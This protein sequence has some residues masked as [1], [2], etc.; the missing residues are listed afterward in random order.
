[1]PQDI[2]KL[3]DDVANSL[4]SGASIDCITTALRLILQNSIDANASEITVSL[5]LRNRALT[6]SDNGL[7]MTRQDLSCFGRQNHTSKHNGSEVGYPK[8]YGFKGCS[9]FD[10]SNVAK[11]T[12]ISRH[13]KALSGW[14]KKLGGSVGYI[15]CP[16]TETEKPEKGTIVTVKDFFHNLP[17]RSKNLERSKTGKILDQVRFDVFEVLVSHPEVKICVN[18]GDGFEGETKLLETRGVESSL[19]DANRLLLCLQDVFGL[20][21]ESS[22][23]KPVHA[24]FTDCVIDG[25]ISEEPRYHRKIHLLFV[26]GLRCEDPALLRPISRAFGNVR[27]HWN[28]VG[29][30][31]GYE[32]YV[33]K[34]S[35]P[36][37]NHKGAGGRH[38]I[39]LETQQRQIIHALVFKLIESIFKVRLN[40][41]DTNVSKTLKRSTSSKM[42]KRLNDS[43][44]L[45]SEFEGGRSFVLKKPKA[46]SS[47]HRDCF[48]P[49]S[50]SIN[51]DTAVQTGGHKEGIVEAIQESNMSSFLTHREHTVDRSLFSRIHVVNQVDKK[52]LLLKSFDSNPDL[53]SLILLD[54]HAADERIKYES[55]LHGFIWGL[56]TAPH[57]HIRKAHIKMDLSLKEYS[58]FQQYKNELY[59]WGILYEEKPSK[60]FRCCIR[61]TALPEPLQNR[62]TDALKNGIMQYAYDL[63]QLR[64]NR[65]RNHTFKNSDLGAAQNFAWWNY[66]NSMPTVINDSL[67][68]KACRSAIMFGDPLSPQ[69][70]ALLVEMLGKCRNPFYCAHGRPSMVPV[71]TESKHSHMNSIGGLNL[72]DYRLS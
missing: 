11:V 9:I 24:E 13:E 20:E 61:I 18:T 70:C 47:T 19:P 27:S 58:T 45:G 21:A 8:T 14:M 63:R 68:S 29:G 48:K 10:I 37:C 6:V 4:L 71:F 12:V 5:D 44:W 7:G 35:M 40:P 17:V 32:I 52:F 62:S 49:I 46:Q 16:V 34:I 31:S 56:L 72:E 64:K 26:N 1:M 2:Q 54:Q 25:L 22:T 55:L 59:Q 60:D 69:E 67:K 43:F 38:L 41:C 42:L 3:T 50:T 33:L 57:L 66:L 30:R 36:T 51:L 53:L 15:S 28:Q 65:F 39:D 23:L